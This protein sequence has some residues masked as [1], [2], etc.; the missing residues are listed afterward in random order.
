MA[1]AVKSY[2]TVDRDI[3]DCAL[4]R[5]GLPTWFRKVYFSFL[6]RFGLGIN[7]P[8]GLGVA[9]R[10]RFSPRM[11]LSTVLVVSLHAPWCRHLKRLKGISPQIREE[12]TVK[13]SEV[14]G[15][16]DQA[17]VEV[18]DVRHEEVIGNDGADG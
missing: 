8:Q 17:M 15:H 12:G 9:W 13:V 4:G 6:E 2:D 10:W 18:G 3:L 14:T 16:A 1:D 7:S 11:P 5:L